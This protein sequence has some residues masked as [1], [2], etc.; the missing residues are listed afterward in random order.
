MARYATQVLPKPKQQL[1]E[2]YKTKKTIPYTSET[3]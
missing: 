3:L 2:F 1:M